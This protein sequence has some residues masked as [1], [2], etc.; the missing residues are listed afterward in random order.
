LPKNIF[1]EFLFA[2]KYC[3][4][5]AEIFICRN[6]YL[7]NFHLPNFLLLVTRIVGSIQWR[8]KIWDP[9]VIIFKKF[10]QKNWQKIGVFDSKQSKLL[11][12]I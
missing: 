10:R 4:N 3:P 12:K 7:R 1:A 11:K 5:F 8:A 2:K 9:N 6:I